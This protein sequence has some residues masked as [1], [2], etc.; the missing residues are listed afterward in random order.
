MFPSVFTLRHAD[1]TAS[2]FVGETEVKHEGSRGGVA[3]T[4]ADCWEMC[5]RL[6]MR[7]STKPEKNEKRD[8]VI[9]SRKRIRLLDLGFGGSGTLVLLSGCYTPEPV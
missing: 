3:E 5:Y 2:D 7:K 4:D 6:S 1:F 9:E 8:S